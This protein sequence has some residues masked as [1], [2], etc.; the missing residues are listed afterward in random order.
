MLSLKKLNELTINSI[1]YIALPHGSYNSDTLKITKE[2]NLKVLLANDYYSSTKNKKF[3]KIN[4]ILM[5]NIEGK[6]FIKRLKKFDF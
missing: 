5:P 3:E 1:Q 4:R 2:L 6:E